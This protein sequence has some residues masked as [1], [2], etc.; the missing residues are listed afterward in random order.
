MEIK[1]YAE[2]LV[3][4]SNEFKATCIEIDF[5]ED[6]M[7]LTGDLVNLDIQWHIMNNQKRVRRGDVIQIKLEYKDECKLT[8]KDIDELLGCWIEYQDKDMWQQLDE[9]KKFEKECI[10]MFKRDDKVFKQCKQCQF[11][12]KHIDKIP[13]RMY[14]CENENHKGEFQW[15]SSREDCKDFKKDEKE[16]KVIKSARQLDCKRKEEAILD[17]GEFPD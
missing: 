10:Q 12:K 16:K 3:L 1:N 5:D 8:E 14:R 15:S 4:S 17:L 2:Y 7:S 9:F 13:H 11:F 6:S